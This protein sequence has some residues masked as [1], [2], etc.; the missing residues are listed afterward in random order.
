[1][2]TG[3]SLF[4]QDGAFD[5]F[6]TRLLFRYSSTVLAGLGR[7]DH[8]VTYNKANRTPLNE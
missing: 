2:Q 3:L 6:Y 1:M 5:N 8:T 7:G 4:P